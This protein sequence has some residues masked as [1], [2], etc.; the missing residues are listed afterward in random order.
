MRQDEELPQ[1]LLLPKNL[2]ILKKSIKQNQSTSITH[3]R[4][5]ITSDDSIMGG[6]YCIAIIEY[7]ITGK[8]L[9]DHSNQFSSNDYQKNGKISTL[10]TDIAKEI[11]SHDFRLKKIDETKNYL[12]DEIKQLFNG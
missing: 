5:R 12:L 6:F 11:A 1:E 7:M 9:L 3:N 4:F 10:K 8:T 2:I